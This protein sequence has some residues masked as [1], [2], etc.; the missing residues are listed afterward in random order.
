MKLILPF[1][2]ILSVL[3][4][5]SV[6]V[7]WAADTNFPTSFHNVYF[8]TNGTNFI[9]VG[10]SDSSNKVVISPWI[11]SDRPSFWYVIASNGTNNSDPSKVFTLK[12]SQPKTATF[13]FTPSPSG[14]NVLGYNVY[15]APPPGR[16]NDYTLYTTLTNGLPSSSMD[17]YTFTMP[18]DHPFWSIVTATNWIYGQES[19]PSNPL[20]AIPALEPPS[21][22]TRQ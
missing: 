16:T 21:N 5:P 13:F 12:A 4:D 2:L 8:S 7:S 15:T 10:G 14:T 17:P 3:G 1:I 6:L 22:Y 20:F 11:P 18:L 19:P 9:L